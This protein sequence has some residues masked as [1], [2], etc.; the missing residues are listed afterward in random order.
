M[1]PTYPTRA[2]EEDYPEYF[3]AVQHKWYE[4]DAFS[5]VSFA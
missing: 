2:Y 1:I 5:A 4:L 3:T